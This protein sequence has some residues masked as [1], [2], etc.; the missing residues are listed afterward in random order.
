MISDVNNHLKKRLVSNHVQMWLSSGYQ[1]AI[2]LAQSLVIDNSPDERLKRAD[3]IYKTI[4]LP[5]HGHNR[6][7]SYK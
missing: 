5:Y 7:I 6:S 4:R 2:K 1:S 3:A